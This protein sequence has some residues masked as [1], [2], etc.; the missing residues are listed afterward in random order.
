MKYNITTIAQILQAEVKGNQNYTIAQLSI[1]SRA[2]N[3][4]EDCLFFAL[5]GVQ[6]NGHSYIQDAYEKGIKSFVI[7]QFEPYFDSM[8]NAVFLKVNNVLQALQQLAAYHRKQF[9]YPVIGVT[10]SNGKT[11]VKEWLSQCL[12]P[13][14]DVVKSPKSYNS[15][16]GVPL[17]V[18]KMKSKHQ[19]GIFEAGISQKGEME[20][21]EAIIQP[22]I[23]I[24]T[25]LGT[26]HQ[27]NFD[28]SE[29]IFLEKIKLFQHSSLIIFPLDKDK[30]WM[31]T[32]LQEHCPQATLLSWGISDKA[33]FHIESYQKE[34][35]KSIIELIYKEKKYLF[36]I[37]FS[38]QALAEDV[39]SVIITMLYLG[40]EEKHINQ[41]ISKLERLKMRLEILEGMYESLIIS[42]VYNSDFDSVK[43]ALGVLQH[44]DYQ[45]KSLVL[46]D[47]D[48]YSASILTFIERLELENFIWIGEAKQFSK[49]LANHIFQ[50]EN[51]DDFLRDFPLKKFENQV[52]LFKGARRF[53][54]EKA[55]KKMMFRTHETVFEINLENLSHNLNYYKSKLKPNTKM[56][57]MVKASSYGSGVY[58]VANLLKFH[59]V[60]YLGVAYP[61]EGIQLRELGIKMPIMIMN[62]DISSHSFLA[63]YQL[64]PEIYN[65]RTLESFIR[66]AKSSALQHY[67]IHIKIDTGMHR[68]GFELKDLEKLTSLL[69]ENKQFIKV[70]SIFSHLAT[71]DVPEEN[72]FVKRQISV[73]E[74]AYQKISEAINIQPIK[75]ILNSAG[76]S[77]FSDYQ[78]DMVRLGIGIY[79]YDFDSEVQKHLKNVSTLKSVVSQIKELAVGETVGYSRR[80]KA[81][82]PTIT[83]TIPIG[84]ADGISR[85]QGNGVGYVLVNQQEAKI[86]GSIC[87]DMLMVDVTDIECNEGDEVIILGEKPSVVELAAWQ[88]TIPYEVLT[89][90][91]PRVKR[92]YYR[93]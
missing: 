75:H 43:I 25:H 45:N 85:L 11:I 78:F 31:Q 26:G 63:Q 91:S 73:F 54:L 28:S 93:D 6:K 87:M 82:R 42:D 40:F 49:T 74:E 65:F 35:K 81:E 36:N 77:H 38:D 84:Y 67:P 58:E 29:A 61:D 86:I 60:D 48:S 7:Q 76:I 9:Q 66:T 5:S 34:T 51:T 12:E 4:T 52:V 8:T 14:Y 64:E 50:Y 71:A 16:I 17:S 62:A 80:F 92:V 44:Q 70:Q 89:S 88:Q 21:L 18:W 27:E 46:S 3:S 37:P 68:L 83:A 20:K 55:V 1:D 57:V 59:Q 19:I 41:K 13:E 47:F 33:D 56:M 39:I 53:R 2:I 69:V 90:I 15:Q 32:L 22:N 10:G 23:G 72:N 30:M 24:F 79:G